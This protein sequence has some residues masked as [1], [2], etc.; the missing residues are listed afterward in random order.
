MF[1]SG[2]PA[3][4]AMLFLFTASAAM[5][6]HGEGGKDSPYAAVSAEE[7]KSSLSGEKQGIYHRCQ[8]AH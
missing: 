3:L 1:K 4:F 6:A 7:V 8:I 2:L 5:A